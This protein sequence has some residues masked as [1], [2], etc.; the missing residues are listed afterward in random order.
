MTQAIGSSGVKW[1]DRWNG[2]RSSRVE[3]IFK[4]S[5]LW[6]QGELDF[7]EFNCEILSE[8]VDRVHPNRP[9][10]PPPEKKQPPP[11]PIVKASPPSKSS[12]S[13]EDILGASV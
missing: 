6:L 1:C 4:L 7:N 9:T 3:L 13:T 10:N 12:T 5:W 2:G 11:P 8:K